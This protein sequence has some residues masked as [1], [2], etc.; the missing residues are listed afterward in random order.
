MKNDGQSRADSLASDKTRGN[1]IT[2]LVIWVK[3]H[4]VSVTQWDKA[5]IIKVYLHNKDRDTLPKVCPNTRRGPEICF[6]VKI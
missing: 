5:I 6:G 2:S 4:K 3:A 1:E